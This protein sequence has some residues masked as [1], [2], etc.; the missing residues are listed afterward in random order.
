MQIYVGSPLWIPAP[1]FREDKL[2][3]NDRTQCLARK[4]LSDGQ[5]TALLSFP[6]TRES[7]CDGGKT[8]PLG[9]RC[10]LAIKPFSGLIAKYHMSVIPAKLVLAKAGSGDP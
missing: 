10:Y 1:R 6:R 2:R 4:T 5:I 9:N 8:P 3:E 7:I